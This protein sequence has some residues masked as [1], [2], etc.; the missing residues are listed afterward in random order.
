MKSRRFFFSIVTVAVVLGVFF[1]LFFGIVKPRF[2]GVITP[3]AD[4]R[5]AAVV[6]VVRVVDAV[7]NVDVPSVEDSVVVVDRVVAVV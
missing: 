7:R 4:T 6:Q 5:V 2:Q 3:V 1:F